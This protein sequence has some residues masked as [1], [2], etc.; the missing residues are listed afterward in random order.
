MQLA[1]LSVGPGQ[2]A[3]GPEF[4]DHWSAGSAAELDQALQQVERQR[5][6]IEAAD[7][8]WLNLA[9][10]RM[11]RAGMLADVET[12]VVI[13]QP[14]PYLAALGL[15]TER[16]AQLEVARSAGSRL[17]GVIKDDSG[18]VCVSAARLTPWVPDHDW[19]V[20]AVVDDQRL[21]DGNVRALTVRHVGPAEV[22]A[23]A[24]LGRFRSRS[25]RGR[26]LQLACDPAQIVTDGLA[27]DR[28]RG[29]RTF[30]AEPK[31]WRLALP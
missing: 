15:P 2:A 24:R 30:W 11:Q 23:E 27:R 17:V 19:W 9:L 21:C 12:A 14:V 7:I 28:P 29:R 31:L 22:R 26:S 13:A 25:A 18:G 8:G 16:Q 5:L 4:T 3:T 20:R 10:A 6:V 1:R